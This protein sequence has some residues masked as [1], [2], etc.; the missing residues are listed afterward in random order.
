MATW[1]L[2]A[3]LRE[4]FEIYAQSHSEKFVHVRGNEDKVFIKWKWK[5]GSLKFCPETLQLIAKPGW[6]ANDNKGTF[7]S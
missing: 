2:S 6:S 5:R 4:N 7:F 1:K 3:G